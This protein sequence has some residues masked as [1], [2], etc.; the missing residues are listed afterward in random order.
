MNLLA[1]KSPLKRDRHFFPASPEA[2][3][4]EAEKFLTPIFIM[5][6]FKTPS[7]FMGFH[8]LTFTFCQS[9]PY[10][11]RNCNVIYYLLNNG[12][13][14]SSWYDFNHRVHTP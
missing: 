12:Y 1:P 14:G 3:T 6:T 5:P 8:F 2:K 7:V 13:F 10:G 11:R 9:H 4:L